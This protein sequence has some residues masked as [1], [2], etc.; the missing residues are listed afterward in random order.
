[1]ISRQLGLGFMVTMETD[2]FS[3]VNV[4]P[5]YCPFGNSK[6]NKFGNRPAR[7]DLLLFCL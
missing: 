4:L 2:S 6:A 1:M 5:L 3:G 7:R